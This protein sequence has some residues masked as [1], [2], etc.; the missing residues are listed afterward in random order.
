MGVQFGEAMA[1]L[2]VFDEDKETDAYW[3]L[4]SRCV[5]NGWLKHIGGSIEF[6]KAM[7]GRDKFT[8]IKKKPGEQKKTTEDELSTIRNDNSRIA[9]DSLKQAR[10]YDQV[11]MRL[12]MLRN[13]KGKEPEKDER[14][15]QLKIDAL[16]AIKNISSMT[17][18]GKGT[19]EMKSKM[20]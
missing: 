6:S 10:R 4:Y 13:N 9:V 2:N 18:N 3:D 17:Y 7:R 20:S 1:R 8:I 15:V 5:E 12:E 19:S 16:N 11:A 14:H